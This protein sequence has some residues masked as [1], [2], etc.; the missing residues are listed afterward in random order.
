[1]LKVNSQLIEEYMVEH[2]L[3]I[4]DIASR[5]NMSKKTFY[6]KITNPA[7]ATYGDLSAIAKLI[8]ISVEKL[9]IEEPKDEETNPARSKT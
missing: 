2:E 9:L 3:T 1:M 4:N 6:R 7:N 5:L 8:G